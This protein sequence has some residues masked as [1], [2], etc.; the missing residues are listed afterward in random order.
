M[1][2]RARPVV[3]HP[4]A[5][6]PER[7]PVARVVAR[8]RDWS[9]AEYVCSAGPGDRSFEEQ[10]EVFT[11]AAVVKGSFRYKTDTGTSLLHPGSWLLGNHGRCFSCGHD[12]S[13]GD[14]VVRDLR[15]GSWN[16][17]VF[18]DAEGV[19]LAYRHHRAGRTIRFFRKANCSA[20]VHHCLVELTCLSG[21]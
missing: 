6:R 5:L 4:V 11:L 12:H 17:S 16:G 7:G 8:G 1:T 3:D 14:R 21:W 20:Q 19:G 10:H 15:L 18:L 2:N 9:A 13:R